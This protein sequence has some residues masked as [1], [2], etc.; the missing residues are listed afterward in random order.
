M[1]KGLGSLGQ[2]GGQTNKALKLDSVGTC[3]HTPAKGIY[4]K[5]DSAGRYGGAQYRTPLEQYDR[6]SDFER[7][8]RGQEYFYSKG[9]AFVGF[10]I[11]V[12]FSQAFGNFVQENR[13][14]IFNY[15][16]QTADD[17]ARQVA[18]RLRDDTAFTQP[19]K[20][21]HLTL[22]TSSP[23]PSQ[24]RLL[25]KMML[26]S[27][28]DGS[29]LNSV[30][31]S[32][33]GDLYE[34][35]YNAD[36]TMISNR[37]AVTSVALPMIETTMELVD[38][39]SQLNCVFDL[40]KPYGRVISNGHLRWRALKYD[41]SDPW[42][43]IWRVDGTRTI[44]P[45]PKVFCD[46]PDYI[47]L[48][49]SAKRNTS[50]TP[51]QRKFPLPMAASGPLSPQDARRA[52][53]YKRWREVSN[54]QIERRDCKHCH[55]TRWRMGLPWWE[56]NDY[57]LIKRH[58]VH[59][60]DESDRFFSARGTDN[61][62]YRNLDFQNVAVSLCGVLGY[63]LNPKSNIYEGQ[64]DE[65]RPLLWETDQMPAPGVSRQNDLWVK[66]GTKQIQIF[67]QGQWAEGF[68]NDKDQFVPVYEFVTPDEVQQWM[69][70]DQA[71]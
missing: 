65:D 27:G 46:C 31:D 24:H 1:A 8:A 45:A 10:P 53:E 16:S 50:G 36:G 23:D 14:I 32:Y 57:S 63:D 59:A 61:L 30:L 25:I 40:S 29:S 34:D 51:P 35:S 9:P 18:W 7:W 71:Q 6:N 4:P 52:G 49:I 66:T 48:D 60:N 39:K 33:I 37:K 69:E 13:I 3:Q 44:S 20:R 22:E 2:V 58:Q 43:T 64:R 28:S 11:G 21:E 17:A 62:K 41:P 56:P 42:E 5:G 19:V 68:T 12:R 54:Q 67:H 26:Y 15:P 47:G 38:G 55:A 70:L